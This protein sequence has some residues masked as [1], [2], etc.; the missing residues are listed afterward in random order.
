[1]DPPSPS[2]RGD[3]PGHAEDKEAAPDDRPRVYVASLA[4]YNAGILHGAWIDATGEPDELHADVQAMLARSPTPGAEEFA[5]HDYEHFG[6]YRVGEYDRLDWV[7]RIARG[8]DEYGLA[9]AAWAE[10][11]GHD[12]DALASFEDAYLG[13]W[14]SV[15]AYAEEL[16]EDLGYL[17]QL[18]QNVPEILAPYVRVDIAAFAHD[19]E[20]GGDITAIDHARGVWLFDGRP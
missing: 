14:D 3:A 9:Y 1:M 2:E 18:D 10:H 15:E 8:I 12:E 4:D 17:D 6:P 11:A 20:L 13:E 19:L 7:S 16:L 5:I